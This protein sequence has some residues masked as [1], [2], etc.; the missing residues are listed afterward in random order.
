MVE[1]FCGDNSKFFRYI[2]LP[3]GT[4]TVFQVKFCRGDNVH[5]T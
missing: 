3:E 5:G 1:K 2:F 4:K